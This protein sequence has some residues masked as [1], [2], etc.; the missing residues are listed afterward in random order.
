MYTG[1][2][3]ETKVSLPTVHEIIEYTLIAH[4]SIHYLCKNNLLA[5]EK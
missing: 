1:N 3:Q 5:M 4:I 2:Y